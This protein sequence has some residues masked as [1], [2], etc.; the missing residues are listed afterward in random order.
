MLP[1]MPTMFLRLSQHLAVAVL[2]VATG[3]RGSTLLRTE[4]QRREIVVVENV[5]MTVIWSRLLV[6]SQM[7]NISFQIWS[8]LER[9]ERW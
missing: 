2:Q 3:L 9:R 7:L 6:E 5:T 4:H 1:L 8:S